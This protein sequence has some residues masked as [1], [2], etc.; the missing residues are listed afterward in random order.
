[1]I[2]FFRSSQLY[3][4]NEYSFEETLIGTWVDGKPLYRKMIDCGNLNTGNT[5]ISI[6]VENIKEAHINLGESY[7][8]LTSAD[9]PYY[10]FVHDDINTVMF[11][12]STNQ[13]IISSNYE[14]IS[15]Y[16]AI[17]CIEY[18]KTTD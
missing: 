1:M 17:V 10:T 9:Y 3:S 15:V 2:Q 13:I 8:Y 5:F 11:Q 18:T 7:W 6:G 12:I 16:K 14:Q 4:K